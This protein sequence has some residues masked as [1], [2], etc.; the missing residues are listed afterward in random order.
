MRNTNQNK[1]ESNIIDLERT[2][3]EKFTLIRINKNPQ[4]TR[5]E[6]YLAV[7]Y[8]Q[9]IEQGISHIRIIILWLED[10]I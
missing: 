10:L 6:R 2:S 7:C 3:A 4:E 8:V 5:F 9:Q 1:N